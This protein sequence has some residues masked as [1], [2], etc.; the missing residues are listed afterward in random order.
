MPTL[1]LLELTWGRE[2]RALAPALDLQLADGE[3]LAVTGPNGAG[4]STLLRTLA[5]LLPP[6]SGAARID[7]W[8]NAAGEEEAR[9]SRAAHYLGHRNALKPTRRVCAEL[10]FWHRTGGLDPAEALDAVAVPRVRDLP[11]AALS[12]GQARRVAIARLLV[13]PRPVWLLDEPSAALD[14][15]ATT[16]LSALCRDFLARGGI[17][18]A[19]THLPLGLDARELRLREPITSSVPSDGWSDW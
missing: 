5:G 13:A 16:R 11:C 4:K 18:A 10:A 14:A 19:A 6:V 2:G 12:A 3:A 1:R 7:G 9:I 8:R 15:D 17:I